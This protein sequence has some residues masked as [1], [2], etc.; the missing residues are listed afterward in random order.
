MSSP[1]YELLVQDRILTDPS[2]TD[3]DVTWQ[4]ILAIK[5][6]GGLIGHNPRVEHMGI[7]QDDLLV[8]EM[9]FQDSPD[10]RGAF[11]SLLHEAFRG[12]DN[13]VH[14]FHVTRE[15]LGYE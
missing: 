12:G 6:D 9:P 3:R 10:H 13:A 7:G 5:K 15:F 8:H 11:F 1:H 14:P 4:E 2:N